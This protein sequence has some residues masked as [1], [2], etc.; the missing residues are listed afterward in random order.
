MARFSNN[1]HSPTR[2]AAL[3]LGAFLLAGGRARK[4][5]ADDAPRLA[6]LAAIRPLVPPVAV[7]GTIA[8]TAYPP[9]GA[10][11]GV[12][13]TIADERG[14]AVLVNVW[15][16]WCGPCVTEMPALAELA[17]RGAAA[18]IA[19]RPV[20]I[21]FGGAAAVQAFYAR[22]GITGLPVLVD[23]GGSVRAGFGVAAVPVSF[24]IDAA[25]MLRARVDAAADWAR[26][27]AVPRLQALL[28]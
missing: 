14:H 11:C 1:R 13:R 7:P 27:D 9:D 26:P 16:T 8:W 12:R 21:D 28:R 20:S 22:A 6:D 24:L 15:A 23:A 3:S 17:R 19:V 5:R 4:S 10:A 25:G 2:R 18:G